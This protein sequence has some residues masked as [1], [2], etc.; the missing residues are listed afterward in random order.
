MRRITRWF[1]LISLMG[2]FYAANVTGLLQRGEFPVNQAAEMHADGWN[3]RVALWNH[4]GRWIDGPQP[5]LRIDVSPCR[6][7]RA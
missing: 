5:A 4:A 6:D 3:F 1:L 7:A 2:Q